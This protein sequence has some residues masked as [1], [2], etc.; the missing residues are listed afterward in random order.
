MI[1]HT[2]FSCDILRHVAEMLHYV[3]AD[4][5]Q[6]RPAVVAVIAAKGWSRG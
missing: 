6:H 1:K 3:K 5:E 4:E 2:V